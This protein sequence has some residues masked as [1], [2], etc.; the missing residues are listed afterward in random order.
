MGETSNYGF[1]L[2]RSG[3]VVFGKDLTD[4]LNDIDAKLYEALHTDQVQVEGIV[5]A[6]NWAGMSAD[7]ANVL[8]MDSGDELKFASAADLTKFRIVVPAGSAPA[9]GTCD[10]ALA[11]ASAPLVPITGVVT[12]P[13]GG[14]DAV[15]VPLV[16]PT[17]IA[18]NEELLLIANGTGIPLGVAGVIEIV[19]EGNV[20]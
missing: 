5:S 2:P 11:L 9:G 1:A 13:V 18:A 6:I 4:I 3:G 8:L 17:N 16:L 7:W 12:V 20:A 19:V 14:I 10:V 15:G